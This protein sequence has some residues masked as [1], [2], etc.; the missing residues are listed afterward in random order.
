MGSC[1]Y[2]SEQSWGINSKR[3]VRQKSGREKVLSEVW[4]PEKTLKTLLGA[5][6]T[7]IKRVAFCHLVKEKITTT[8]KNKS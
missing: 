7:E 6:G 1:I 4:F 8:L 3:N 5:E 2:V